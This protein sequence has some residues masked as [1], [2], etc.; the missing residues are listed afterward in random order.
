MDFLLTTDPSFFE[1]LPQQV[2]NGVAKGSVY[3]LIA[4]GYTMVY[5]VLQLI[6]FAHGEIYMLG[7]Y[8]GYYPAKWA[9]QVPDTGAKPVLPLYVVGMVFLG[10]IAFCTTLGVLIERFAYKPLR[11]S[12]RLAA[13]ITAIG[14]SLFLQNLAIMIFGAA[15]KGYPVVMEQEP[16]E[17]LGMAISNTKVVIIVVAAI[18]MVGLHLFVQKTKRGAAMRACSHDMKTARLMGVNVDATVSLTFALGSAMA[19]VGGVLVAIDQP[20]IDPLMG[21]LI[22]LKAFIAAVL[23]GIGSI[24]GAAIGGLLLGV[25]ESVV[26][27]YSTTYSEAVAFVILI[28]VLLVKP[29]GI[30]GKAGRE[31]V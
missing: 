6:N 26:G 7:A 13:L 11:N 9:G 16:V 1:Q 21:L 22:G 30:L 2:A 5:G 29:S 19:A 4:V 14:V 17:L 28:G 10:A 15:P 3:A 27:I 18:M 20:S 8:A 12:S 23:G 31:K 25:S 24:P